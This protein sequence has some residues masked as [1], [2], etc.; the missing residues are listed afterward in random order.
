ML[1]RLLAVLG[2]LKLKPSPIGATARSPVSDEPLHTDRAILAALTSL[3]GRQI[4]VGRLR[5]VLPEIVPSRDESVWD[6]WMKV[7]EEGGYACEI[8]QNLKHHQTLDYILSMLRYHRPG[9]DDLP[10]E[11]RAEFLAET[12]S[13]VNVFLEAL[14]KLVSFLEHGVPD[15]RGPLPTKLI[16]RDVKAA[17]LK[18]VD[19]LTYREVAGTL[20]ILV[21]ADFGVKGDHPAVRRMVAR[22]REV[23][24]GA[25]G[26]EGWLKQAEAMRAE[27]SRWRSLDEAGQEAEIGAEALGIADDEASRQPPSED[28]RD[29][30]R[31]H[32]SEIA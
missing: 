7:I 21:P 2:G 22:G 15:R 24:E 18:D 8:L 19:G 29:G 10:L 4:D 27:A 3:E 12:S 32:E 30:V 17:V 14:R 11:E 6:R 23:L 1:R 31:G 5:K 25:L 16:G 9:F 28:E 20:C 26:E 13:Y